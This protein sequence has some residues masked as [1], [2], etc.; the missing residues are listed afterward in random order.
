MRLFL[1]GFIVFIS[2]LQIKNIVT[3]HIALYF[4][5]RSENVGM[6]IV[7]VNTSNDSTEVSVPLNQNTAYFLNELF[8]AHPSSCRK[9][10][11][12]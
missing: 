9:P 6:N 3:P 5:T 7:S 10:I 11:V 4:S 1:F 12:R 2:L 8:T